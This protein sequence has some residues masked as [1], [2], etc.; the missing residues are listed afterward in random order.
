MR[1]C[2]LAASTISSFSTAK[3][4][5]GHI[6]RKHKNKEMTRLDFMA[7]PFLKNS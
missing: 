5:A 7:Y 2:G 4:A 6:T 1:L 3:A